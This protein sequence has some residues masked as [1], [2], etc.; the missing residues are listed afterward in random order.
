MNP[1]KIKK[2]LLL[3]ITFFGYYLTISLSIAGTSIFLKS[4]GAQYLPFFLVGYT[5]FFSIF[6]F[7]NAGL[8]YK[9]SAERQ[10]AF[11]IASIIV[12]LLIAQWI[13]ISS[14]AGVL[15]LEFCGIFSLHVMNLQLFNLI[16]SM[17]TPLQ[18]KSFVPLVN[19]FSNTGIILG[20]FAF[21]FF[22]RLGG[23]VGYGYLGA[24]SLLVLFL[25]I[26][27]IEIFFSNKSTAKS[28]PKKTGTSVNNKGALSEVSETARFIFKQS[29][30]FKIFALIMFF[31]YGVRMLIEFKFNATL[32]QALSGAEL[33]QTIGYVTGIVNIILIIVNTF[34]LKKAIFKF[35]VINS[36]IFYPIV[37][38]I[39]TAIMA[40]VNF[41]YLSVIGLYIVYAVCNHSVV[42]VC[43]E[44]VLSLLPK[45]KSRSG[46]ILVKGLIYGLTSFV[47][48]LILLIY[49][50]RLDLE[51]YLN[52]VIIFIMSFIFL[53]VLF[54]LKTLYF[55]ELKTNLFKEDSYLKL[56]SIDLLAE[57][58]YRDR[59]ENYLRMMLTLKTSDYTIKSKVLYSLGIIGNYQTIADLIGL[60]KTEEPKIK[61]AAIQSINAIIQNRKTLN[62]YPVSKYLLLRA[63]EDLLLLDTPSYIKLEIIHSL[64]YFE[65]SEV[66]HFLEDHL[67]SEDNKF[68]VNVIETLSSFD[69]RAIMLYIKPYLNSNDLHVVSVAIMALWQFKDLR[70]NLL[71]KFTSILIRK[72]DE[73]ISASLFLIGEIKA[74][75]EKE[76]V[77]G[78]L[79]HP[80]LSIRHRALITLIKL[81]ETFRIKDFIQA[82]ADQSLGQNYEEME[83]LLSSLRKMPEKIKRNI[84]KS[85]QQMPEAQVEHIRSAMEVSKYVFS[86]ELSSLS[87]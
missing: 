4:I 35:G 73:A 61:F 55:D 7:L 32:G 67:A 43:E 77:I 50:V 17:L 13:G 42:L 51:K 22:E 36:L 19:A 62:R 28:I 80:S 86:Q 27:S 60:L 65:L 63:Y 11:I 6:S 53:V 3:A 66:I 82:I 85:I 30:L 40:I 37:L 52:S 20:S 8:S 10:F 24:T 59:G 74:K 2:I 84:I 44:Q 68:V 83:F 14:T 1:D 70:I 56:R 25:L 45:E 31:I 48:S 18:S 58:N 21:F 78:Q 41:N 46:Y 75:W 12:L 5:L 38:L 71:T 76:Y 29:S 39:S 34:I 15:I 79:K 47:F 72:D 81:G 57:Q 23:A 64:K 9:I 33:G 16:S 26:I 54:R 69:D 49:T 87:S